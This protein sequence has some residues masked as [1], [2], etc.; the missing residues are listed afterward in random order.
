M[1]FKMRTTS[2]DHFRLLAGRL[3]SATARL[4]DPAEPK[5]NHA[6]LIACAIALVVA[7]A[8]ILA[9]LR[10]P[11]VPGGADRPELATALQSLTLFAWLFSIV[12]LFGFPA[13]RETERLRWMAL[14]LLVASQTAAFQFVYP[15]IGSRADVNATI[16][17]SLIMWTVACACF[18]LAEAP[19]VPL[20][21]G[22]Q[23]GAI[24]FAICVGLFLCILYFGHLLPALEPLYSGK[25]IAKAITTPLTTSTQ[26]RVMSLAPLALATSALLAMVLRGWRRPYEG[27]ILLAL[28]VLTVAELRSIL[29]PAGISPFST[30]DPIPQFAFVGLI[31]CG[32]L[33]E[34]RR[35]A[36]YHSRS[37]AIER[38]RRKQLADL[39]VL[40]ADFSAMAAHELGG[41]T[42]AVVA[43]VEMLRTGEL[44]ADASDNALLAIKAEAELLGT[45]VHDVEAGAAAER[46]DFRLDVRRASV[47]SIV[48]RALAFAETLPG[49]HQISCPRPAKVFVWADALRID[50]VL[51][52]LC[53][54]AAKYSPAGSAIQLRASVREEF[55]RFEVVDDGFGIRSEDMEQILRRFGRGSNE[56][57]LKKKG[58]GLG[59]YLSR[60]ILHA[61][62]SELV[63]ESELGKG[64][65]FGF[66]LRVAP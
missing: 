65:T 13:E 17:A 63:V 8:G 64:S 57:A 58:L 47:E 39:A 50:Q 34:L 26:Y 35:V 10:L 40:K 28:L 27:W 29:W 46:E 6:L 16:L 38:A 41:H 3:Q 56:R 43:L 5:R 44:D 23:R 61:H 22:W 12:T 48:A 66:D 55:V 53:T 51:S 7:A 36:L 30:I 33:F 37:L 2:P 62:G 42:A 52:N 20:G 60:R 31:A 4:V 14:G 21:L 24:L 54:N 59:L 49:D 25:S 9:I 19:N 15:Y 32:G 11:V 18:A 1:K 45:L